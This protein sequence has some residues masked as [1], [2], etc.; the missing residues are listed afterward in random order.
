MLYLSHF[1]NLF[2]RRTSADISFVRAR[3]FYARPNREHASRN[4]IVG[5]PC[6]RKPPYI[7]IICLL[8]IAKMCLTD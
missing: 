2:I 6:T 5:L 7:S 3:M 4:I 1:A 8:T